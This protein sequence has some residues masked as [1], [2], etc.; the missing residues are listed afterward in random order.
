MDITNWIQAI[1][2]VIALLL[3]TIAIIQTNRV[4][5]NA[6]KPYIS[7]Y[8]EYIQVLDD[9]HQYISI[10]NFGSTSATITNVIVDP[11]VKHEITGELILSHLSGTSIAPGQSF[12]FIYSSNAFEHTDRNKVNFTITITYRDEIGKKFKRSFVMDQTGKKD[13]LN[14]K[15]TTKMP[16]SEVIS[17]TS[18]E[19]LRRNI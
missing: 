18:E 3:S 17:R 13:M 19:L 12:N 14:V 6:N 2:S 7:I 4:T 16:I 1:S 10:K 5:K 9:V 15:S 8:F 11:E